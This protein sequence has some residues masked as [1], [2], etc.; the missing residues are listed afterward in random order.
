MR[1]WRRRSCARPGFVSEWRDD[2]FLDG[3]LI[4]RQPARGFRSGA[5]AVMLAAACPVLPGQ[6]LLELGCGAGVASLCIAW[7][8]PEAEVIGLEVQPEYADLARH[9][10]LTNQAKLEVM[11]GDLTRMPDV[12]KARSF[13]HV[14]AN[15]PYFQAGTPA[16]EAGRH[17]ARQEALALTEWVDAALR[18][19]RTGGTLTM[20]QRVERL[21]DILSSAA[22]RAGGAVVL[23]ISARV[24]RPPERIIVQLVK[25]SK[26]PMR[27]LFPFIMHA[28]A[29]HLRDGEDLSPAARAV[30][31]D[32]LPI[33]ELFAK[34]S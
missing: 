11:T 22:D 32:G 29:Q 27:L 14:I 34:L 10:A 15:P 19:L 9:N 28:R 3:R 26:R 4:V 21:P 1:L 17:L 23:P 5:D 8:V 31:R 6:T 33:T 25:G 18:R 24:G 30:L 12:L 7:R 13:D 2:G 20:I 16:S